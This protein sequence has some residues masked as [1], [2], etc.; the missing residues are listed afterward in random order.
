MIG[1]ACAVGNGL[2][3]GFLGGVCEKAL[4]IELARRGFLVERQKGLKVACK[5]EIVAE[6]FADILVESYLLLE[7]KAVSGLTPE[8]RAQA[9]NY[10]KTTGLSVSL[11]INFGKPPNGGRTYR[12]AAR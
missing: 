2:G 4:S 10:L 1:C 8:Y 7:I 6:Y 12:L 5:G 11:R 9:I 3:P